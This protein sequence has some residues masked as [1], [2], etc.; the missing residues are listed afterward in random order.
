M[1][2]I[3][4][5][6]I[7]GHVAILWLLLLFT[8]W[9]ANGAILSTLYMLFLWAL[10]AA[11]FEYGLFEQKFASPFAY[12]M[13]LG[14]ESLA[15]NSAFYLQYI[16][17]IPAF[18]MTNA[19]WAATGTNI[20]LM[21]GIFYYIYLKKPAFTLLLFAPAILNFSMFSLRDPIIA[22][23]FFWIAVSQAEKNQTLQWAK[24][25]VLAMLFLII[26]PENILIVV[27]WRLSTLIDWS[28]HA[29]L[30]VV[31]IPVLL[32]A[33]WGAM[34]FAPGLLGVGG[35]GNQTSMADFYQDRTTRHTA[36][37][38]GKSNILNGQ[39]A[40]LPLPLRYPIQVFTFFVL[41]LPFE[42][43]TMTLALAFLD[44]IVFCTLT[45]K[46]L[47]TRNKV[48]LT[49][50]AVYVLAVAYFSG[51]YGNVFRIRL[52]AYFIIIGGLISSP[53][54][55]DTALSEDYLSDDPTPP[56]DIQDYQP[57]MAST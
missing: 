27:L 17:N 32:L 7:F 18:I 19:W 40:S 24:Q 15:N 33:A 43:R 44:S 50:L 25:A 57:S 21:S 39:L 47:Q 26:R 13:Y 1:F 28:K 10:A 36:N 53:H 56:D 46:L 42:I 20:A 34:S 14:R 6:A 12:D 52:P 38:T 4:A 5:A 30:T 22:A 2:E 35:A 55:P 31:M 49:F 16:L 23:L 29:L 9:D 37:D 11:N 45:W 8:R 54:E 48:A 51:N 41:P 3:L